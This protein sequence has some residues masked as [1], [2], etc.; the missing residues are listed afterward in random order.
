MGTLARIRSGPFVGNAMSRRAAGIINEWLNWELLG[1]PAR[2]DPDCPRGPGVSWGLE[3]FAMGYGVPRDELEE[4][5]GDLD[6]FVLKFVDGKIAPNS[7][8]PEDHPEPYGN[9]PNAQRQPKP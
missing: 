7:I 2:L 1:G 6:E 9:Q 8:R 4:A 3:A 5:V